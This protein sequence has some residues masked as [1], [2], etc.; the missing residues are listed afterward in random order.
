MRLASLLAAASVLALA[1][2]ADP[3]PA[4]PFQASIRVQSDPGVPVPGAL[5]LR[6]DKQIAT[7]GPD[8]RAM[9]SVRGKEG[10]VAEVTIRCP[11]HL[12][13][14]PGRTGIKLARLSDQR[15]AEYDVACPPMTRRVVVAI[16]AE[17]GPFLPVVY[18]NRA[19][20]RTDA[21]GAAHFALDV[22]PDSSF[23]V[24]LDTSQAEKLKP[25][26]PTRPFVVGRHDDILVFEQKFEVEKPKAVRHAG[27]LIPR[28]VNGR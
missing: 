26:N 13:Q 4:P 18:L 24:R 12:Q 6:G 10:D 23:E 5:V 1:S 20:A 22:A 17:N 2:C 15:A 7:T 3:P 21:S 25:Q 11:D 14:P 19:V 27:P 8:G 9:I 16:R 28:P